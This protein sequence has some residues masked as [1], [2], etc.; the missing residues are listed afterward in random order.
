MRLLRFIALSA[1]L[2][3]SLTPLRASGSHR[4]TPKL[5]DNVALPPTYDLDFTLASNQ[6]SGMAPIDASDDDAEKVGAQVFDELIRSQ[7]VTGLGLPYHW[8]FSVRNTGD[9]NA[10]SL[11]DGEVAAYR[12]LAQLIG[13]NKGLW[14]AVLSHEISHVTRR[15]AVRKALFKAAIDQQIEYWNLR[16]RLGDKNAGWMVLGIRVAGKIAEQKLSRDLENDADK[17][18]MLLMARAG[19]HPDF[20]FAMH[21]LLRASAGEQSKLGAFFST[22]PRWETRDQRSERAYGDAMVEYSQLWP[23]PASSPGGSPPVVAFL[24]NVHAFENKT[25][26]SGDVVLSLSCRNATQPIAMILRLSS[27]DGQPIAGF[28]GE[29]R[30]SAGNLMIKRLANCSDRENAPNTT[31]HIPS[32]LVDDHRKRLKAQIDLFGPEDQRLETSKAIDLHLPAPGKMAIVSAKI[33][34]E[35]ELGDAV[36]EVPAEVEAP[37]TPIRVDQSAALSPSPEGKP[38]ASLPAGSKVAAP[39]V[40]PVRLDSTERNRSAAMTP[41]SDAYQH[42]SQLIA[43]WWGVD[44]TRET[45]SHA[46]A[47]PQTSNSTLG[48]QAFIGAWSDKKLRERGDGVEIS[49][50]EPHGPAEEAGLR[51]GDFILAFDGHYVFTVEDLDADIQRYSPGSRVVLR[52][53][54]HS[55]I[56]DSQLIMGQAQPR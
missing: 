33:Q 3:V 36:A 31:I 48:K 1:I 35:P 17:Q 49:R 47:S 15:H 2:L 30:D 37:V 56:Y 23:V 39:R 13:N 32:G 10:V 8:T 45:I 18:G 21:H 38:L 9:V 6:R 55:T 24:G 43:R 41:P 50:V 46:V 4:A 52:Y 44:E 28:P 25:R 29:F 19:Y 5:D 51:I 16:Q 26:Q 42:D 40:L 34:I 54:H 27:R 11:P 20:V 14:A 53:R 7:M 12:G 22:H